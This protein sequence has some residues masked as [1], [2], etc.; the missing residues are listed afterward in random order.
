MVLS[1]QQPG[2]LLQCQE[3]QSPGFRAT[4]LWPLDPGR[5]WREEDETAARPEVPQNP[6]SLDD[7]VATT[8]DA[9]GDEQPA[10][11]GSIGALTA[12]SGQP[13]PSKVSDMVRCLAE[14]GHGSKVTLRLS[15][16]E[17]SSDCLVFTG[18]LES[19]VLG[20]VSFSDLL[21]LP[22]PVDRKRAPM[23]T[24][25]MTSPSHLEAISNKGTKGKQRRKVVKSRLVELLLRFCLI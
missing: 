13:E 23:R 18:V 5:I 12:G 6:S 25:N 4:G 1:F 19:S 17:S 7:P 3:T 16:G 15:F 9:N 8:E 21:P 20:R 22:P 11:S 14:N 2:N 24:V 10:T